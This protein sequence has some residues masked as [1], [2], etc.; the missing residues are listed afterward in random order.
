MSLGSAMS[1]KPNWKN[2]ENRIKLEKSPEAQAAQWNL[3]CNKWLNSLAQNY[4]QGYRVAESANFSILSNEGE[5]YVQV[6]S[7]FLELTLK[8]ILSAL[9]GIA[10][11]R[12]F[13]K[14]VALVF[15]DI[16]QY[17]DYVGLFY[18]DEGEYG[19]SSGMYIN[20][21][22]G[23]FAFPAQ[24][25]DFVEPIAVHELTHACL[26]HLPLPLWLN[27]GLAVLMEEAQTGNRLFL[28]Q[29]LVARHRAFWNSKTIQGFWSGESFFAA[30]EGQEQCCAL[31]RCR[32]GSRSIYFWSFY[33]RCRGCIS[34]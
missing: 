16:E 28:D 26:A 11:N 22:Y 1:I 2:I 32:G 23:H 4:G 12:D 14:H 25:M 29:E 27:E 3:E 8:R 6:F 18:P 13:G 34:G 17:Y 9:N 15:H 24:E 5:R 31:R 21:G 19:L 20:E 7:N 30:D 33:C 10:S